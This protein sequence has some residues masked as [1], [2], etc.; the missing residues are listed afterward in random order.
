MNPAYTYDIHFPAAM[1]PEKKYPVIFTLHGKG[2]NEK[3]L[4]GLVAPLA[5]EF[6]LIGIRGNLR[7]GAGY[8]YYELKSLGNPV[9][10]MF[11]D[12]M[13]QLADFIQ[14]ATEKYPID[15]SKRYLLGFSQGAILSMSLAL[16][17]GDQ[18]KGIVAM[19][20][21]IPDFVKTEY[22]LRSIEDVSVFLSHGESDPVFPVQVGLKTA[23]YLNDLTKR[24]TF[25]LY[26]SGHGV[27]KEN[28]ADL[29]EWLNK[30]AKL[31]NT[32]GV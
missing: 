28:W 6:I 1:K 13:K 9:R 5:E 25:K 8:Q 31:N 11:D 15:P 20:G 21:Y 18:L 12:A 26:K 32:I 10:G 17:L 29:L 3:D 2:S 14:Y 16:T 22:S 27:T 24:L 4:F 23:A 19:N 7:A 30:D